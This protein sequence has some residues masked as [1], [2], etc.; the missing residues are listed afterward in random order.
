MPKEQYSHRFTWSHLNP[1]QVGRYAEY[2]AK[3]EFTVSGFEVYE[4][5]VDARGV[6]FIIRNSSGRFYEIQ[7]KSHRGMKY[8]FFPKSKFQLSANLYALIV[9]FFEGEEPQLCLIPSEAWLHLD[10]LFKS[11]NYP[12]LKSPPEWGLELSR[13]NL[14]E[15]ERYEYHKTVENLLR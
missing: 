1:L 7:V 9:L 13:K 5:E 3:M 2:Y 12:G 15:L 14:P 10:S 8:I 6:D 11:R 4:P